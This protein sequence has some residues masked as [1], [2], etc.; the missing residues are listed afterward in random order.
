M[1]QTA[2]DISQAIRAQLKVLDPSISAEP[3]TPERKIIDTV[4]EVVAEATI[5]QY[6]LNYQYDIDTKVGSDLDKFISLFGFSRQRGR[7]STGF[8]TFSRATPADRDILIA[9]GTQVVKPATS[10]TAPSIFFTTASVVLPLGS[11]SVEAPIESSSDG[12]L[13]NVAANTILGFGPGLPNDISE[14]TNENATTGGTEEESDAELRV[15][16]KNT[17]FRNIAG[18]QDQFLA[19]AIASR[20]SHKANVIGPI[21]RFIEYVQVPAGF[22]ITSQIPYTKYTYDFDYYLTNGVLD[23]EVFYDPAGVDYTFSDAEPPTITIDDT[24]TLPVGTVLLLEHSYCSSNS[25]NDPAN[26]VLNYVDVYVSG[27]NVTEALEGARFPGSANDFNNTS[28][29]PFYASNFKRV[30]TDVVP[31]I[32]HRFQGLLW[33]PVISLP[34]TIVIG[35]D[36]FHEGSDYWLVKDIT[37][38][39]NSKRAR[40][41]IEWSATALGAIA[42]SADFT[43][44]YNFDKLPIQLNELMDMHKQITT[45]VLVHSASERYFVVNLIVMYTPGYD[46]TA[47]NTAITTALTDFMERLNFGT[48]VQMADLVDVVHDVPGVDNVRLAMPSDGV[49]YGVQEVAADGTTLIGTPKTTDFAVTDSDLAILQTV[50]LTRRSQNTWN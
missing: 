49:A 33:Q 30:E 47:V 1:A 16:F 4:A 9:A 20:Y 14:V 26:D 27:Q 12:V 6:I 48:F 11:T 24:T 17:I 38:Y 45:D 13:G 32:G 44:T 36:T 35:D 34:E 5:D 28:S 18:T 22:V 2:R 37:V 46:V 15:R 50:V 40:N 25:R 10:V 41:G 8:V 3:L 42:A 43:L 29:S 21:S 39:K 7:R 19:L 23:A 31:T